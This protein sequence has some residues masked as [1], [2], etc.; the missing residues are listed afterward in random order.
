MDNKTKGKRVLS[1]ECGCPHGPGPWMLRLGSVSVH[2]HAKRNPDSVY[3]LE[4]EVQSRIAALQAEILELK[5]T[6][7]KQA[8]KQHVMAVSEIHEELNNFYSYQHVHFLLSP[9]GDR[10]V[11]ASIYEEEEKNSNGTAAVLIDLIPLI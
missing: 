11:V 3:L 2:N 4:S 5:E 1:K 9:G 6:S 10:F 8:E 7:E